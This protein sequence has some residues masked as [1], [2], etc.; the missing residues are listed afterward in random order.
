VRLAAALVL[1]G[2]PLA[3]GVAGAQTQALLDCSTV[4]TPPSVREELANS[5]LGQKTA[6][7]EAMIERLATAAETCAQANRLPDEK[8]NAYFDYSIA[9]LPHD[10]LGARLDGLG[11][12]PKLVDDALDF[13]PGRSNPVLGEKLSQGQIEALIRA[14]AAHGLDTDK[15]A[16]STWHMVGAYAA[17]TSLMWQA[18]ARLQ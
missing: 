16:E 13:G 2:G 4:A 5:M 9:R 8:S 6:S 15:V 12:P 11:V 17:A 3:P 10:T 7:S 1:A 18:L 14:L